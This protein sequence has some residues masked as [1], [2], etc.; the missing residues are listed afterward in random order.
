MSDED[1]STE[2][3]R[4]RWYREKVANARRVLEDHEDMT[5]AEWAIFDALF[6]EPAQTEEGKPDA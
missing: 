1:L 2:E 6:G 4:R 3:R 5:S